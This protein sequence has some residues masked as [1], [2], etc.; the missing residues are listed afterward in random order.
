[1]QLMKMASIKPHEI[2]I[3]LFIGYINDA[4]AS[5]NQY[6]NAKYCIVSQFSG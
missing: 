3:D 4:S 6:R 1:M 5:I 2:F